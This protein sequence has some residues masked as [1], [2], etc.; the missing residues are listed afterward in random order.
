VHYA[1]FDACDP[2]AAA[3]GDVTC[4][5]NLNSAP[6]AGCADPATPVPG[7]SREPLIAFTNGQTEPTKV[8]RQG[9]NAALSDGRPPLN[10]LKEIPDFAV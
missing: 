9:L 7:C 2:T 5:P 10:I 3:I 4:A 8:Q 6:S 1:S